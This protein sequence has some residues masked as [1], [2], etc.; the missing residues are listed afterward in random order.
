MRA[1]RNSLIAVAAVLV[2]VALGYAAIGCNVIRWQQRRLESRM[3]EAGMSER[4]AQVGDATVHYWEGGKGPPILFVH[5]FGASA[6]WQWCGQVEALAG[7]HHVIVPDLLWCGGSSSTNRDFS[8][9]HQVRTLVALLDKVGE[10]TV[11][12]VGIS[13]GGLAAYD[14][15]S[16]YPDRVSRLVIVDSPGCAYKRADYDDLLRRFG[17]PSAAAI[18]IPRREEDVDRLMSL[19]YSDPPWTPGFAKRQ[20]LQEMYSSLRE[21]KTALLEALVQSMDGRPG[22]DQAPD[23]QTLIIWGRD[24]QVFPLAIGERLA[25]SLGARARLCIIEKARHAPNLEHAGEVNAQLK[26]FL[27]HGR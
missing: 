27:D 15:T 20:V 7:D 19:A 1:R 14:L 18:L 10:R 17:L 8:L 5:G 24:D 3:T 23:K 26:A 22:C 16:R 2:V 13:Y 9:D 6:V 12:V 21:E 25:A 11:D 4:V